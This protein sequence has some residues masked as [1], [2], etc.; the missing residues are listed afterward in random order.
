MAYL[1]LGKSFTES[2]DRF[3]VQVICRFVKNEEVGTAKTIANRF[4]I[5]E[6]SLHGCPLHT[7]LWASKPLHGCPLYTPLWASK[8]LH[9]CPQGLPKPSSLRDSTLGQISRQRL[10]VNRMDSCNFDLRLQGRLCIT[11][12]SMA[13][14]QRWAGHL[15]RNLAII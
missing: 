8:P 1:K 15:G 9:G 12:N 14:L 4:I 7:P 10:G 2:F 13:L 3:H 11:N 6:V 5:A